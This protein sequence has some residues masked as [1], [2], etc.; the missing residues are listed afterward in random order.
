MQ[1]G[2]GLLRKIDNNNAT[3]DRHLVCDIKEIEG[4]TRVYGIAFHPQ[5]EK[6][7]IVF[8]CYVLDADN[9][10]GSK[11]VRVKATNVE[12][13]TIDLAKREIVLEWVAGGHNGGSLQFGP[14]DGMMYVSTGDSGPAFPPDPKQTGQD[15]SDLMASILR[16]DVDH[17]DKGRAYSIPK[18][19]PFADLKGAR[20]EIWSYGHRNPWRMSFDPATNDLWV[21][22]VGWEMWEMI[23]RVKPGDN[24]GGKIG[25]ASGRE[26]G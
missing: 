15:V 6:N 23:Y 4:V 8:L 12:P 24:Y 10:V 13:L 19:N 7:H 1:N 5:F 3:D 2:L 25:G 17:A 22:D 14:H 20:G 18:D 26:R 21:G 9:P 16:I 11:V